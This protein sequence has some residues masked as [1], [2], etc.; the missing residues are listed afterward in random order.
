MRKIFVLAMFVSVVQCFLFV[1]GSRQTEADDAPLPP[2]Q[3]IDGD[4]SSGI[5]DAIFYLTW[6]F[7]RGPAPTCPTRVPGLGTGQTTCYDQNGQVE[8]CVDGSCVG[9][10]GF[11]ANGCPSEGRFTDNGDGTVTDSCTG[12]VWQ[13]E[14]GNDGI[15][16]SW[17]E[18]LSYCE[19]LDLA[20][21]ED[22][23]LP[24]AKE[25]QSTIDYERA[26]PAVDP[27]FG[28][29]VSV[30]WSSTSYAVS[31]PSA[32]W[33][34]SLHSG[35]LDEDQKIIEHNVRA[36][37]GEPSQQA[38]A[39]NAS[40]PPCHDING[41]GSSD[42]TDAIFFLMW[43]FFR[44]PAPTCPTRVPGLG[45][46]QRTCYDQNGQVEDCVGGSCVG[47]D[48]FYAN[49][50]PSEDRFTD[51]G[52]GTVTDSCTGLVWQ[53]EVGNGGVGMSWCDSLSY[54]AGLELAG[55]DNWRLPNVKELQSIIDYER[56][57]FAIDPIFEWSGATASAPREYWSST[58]YTDNPGSAWY[59]GIY[60]GKI[61]NARKHRSY[62]VRAVRDGP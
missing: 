60:G 10:D 59:V 25:L 40:L 47:Q 53:Q 14:V 19:R 50:C 38:R 48:G 5:T 1:F 45:T 61:L 43:Q 2:C 3:D 15:R 57:G 13:Q 23:R 55:H 9:Q 44:G 8:D 49:G 35:H 12:L 16:M 17:C 32:A 51:N 56:A 46:G 30:L 29:T 31:P 28:S 58:T 36:V 52:D 11:Y 21:Y 34:M 62:V 54:C 41:D 26:G 18:S 7:F 22:W 4:G 33:Y 37:R 6:Q 24:N 20:G 27:I 39:G 42:M